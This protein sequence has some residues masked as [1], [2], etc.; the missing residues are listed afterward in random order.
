[1]GESM[2]ILLLTSEYP[3]YTWGGLGRYSYEVYHE[4]K[5][6]CEVD[7]LNVPTY[8]IL[9]NNMKR[10]SDSEEVIYDGTNRIIHILDNKMIELFR[11][12]NTLR[13][14]N[15][16]NTV[17]NLVNK[18]MNILNRKYD[19][20]FVQDY[21]NSL[22]AAFLL[23]N[24]FARKA[25]SV[26]HLPLY[27]GFTYFDKPMSDEFHQFLES[28]LLRFSCKVIVPSLFTKRVLIQIYSIYPDDVIVNP[29]GVRL[30]N[31]EKPDVNNPAI[32]NKKK[33]YKDGINILS[34]TRFTEQKGLPYI[35]DILNTLENRG[36]NFRY[37][38]IGKGPREKDFYS[39]ANKSS[40]LSRIHH[41]D[42]EKD[43]F[44]YYKMSDIYL[45]T[46]LYETFGL[47]ILEAMACECI[48]VAF[49]VGALDEFIQDGITGLFAEIN[50][51]EGLVNHIE[52]LT[53]NPSKLSVM[54]KNAANY[55]ST[56]SWEPH[57]NVL[58]RVF[59]GCL[60]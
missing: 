36:I 53:L 31:V 10:K 26:C 30:P 43:V 58:L 51:T 39:L 57:V 20:I 56:R 52:D 27:A 15:Y 1:M 50:D 54:K 8:Y 37:T 4:L 44:S 7:I 17:Q 48:P 13:F 19:I 45:S 23:M 32:F 12:R 11:N 59:R 25:V 18:A 29:L 40:I 34:V 49:R 46:S 35:I 33:E 60:G 24:N 2:R 16:S 41:I 3:P 22:I 42:F 5:K 47:S 6:K 14:D 28:I 55:A 38:I 9:L 21:Y